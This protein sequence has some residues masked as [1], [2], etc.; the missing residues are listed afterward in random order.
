MSVVIIAPFSINTSRIASGKSYTLAGASR[1]FGPSSCPCLTDPA[2]PI[3]YSLFVNILIHITG[4]RSHSSVV[5]RP[6]DPIYTIP[7]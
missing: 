2:N 7:F 5:A 4:L 1:N 3:K 6:S